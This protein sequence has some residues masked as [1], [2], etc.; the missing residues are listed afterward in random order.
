LILKPFKYFSNLFS[1]QLILKFFE[2]KKEIVYYGR[3][4]IMSKID[5]LAVTVS[6]NANFT[7]KSE[8]NI[9]KQHLNLNRIQ[10]NFL[11][12]K[13]LATFNNFKKIQ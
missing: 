4:F 10:V 3:F 6:K 9:A 2:K 8:P 5:C 11:F 13:K 7:S 1:F 12:Q